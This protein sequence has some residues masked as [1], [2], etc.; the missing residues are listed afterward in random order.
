[1]PVKVALY[2]GAVLFNVC[3]LKKITVLTDVAL[4]GLVGIDQHFRGDYGFHQE[5][6]GGSKPLRS[7]TQYLPD[8]AAQYPRRLPSSCSSL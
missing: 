7:V 8:C 3:L 1:V 6:E 5:C 2:V 4:C